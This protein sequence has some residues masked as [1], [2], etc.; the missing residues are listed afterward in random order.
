[1]KTAIVI[2]TYNEA[3]NIEKLI[4]EILK[5]APQADI[6]VVDDNSPD[7]TAKK[8][9]KLREDNKNIHCLLRKEN[10]GRGFAGVAGFQYALS[11]NA[12]FI[13]E[14]DAD[15]SHDPRYIPFFI[16]AIKSADVVIGSRFIKGGEDINRGIVRRIVSVLANAYL[17]VALGVRVKDCTSGYRCFRAQALKKIDLNTARSSGPSILEEILF[18]CRNLT[19]KEI[20]ICFVDR[21][22]GS[23][24][25]DSGKLLQC[26]FIPWVL[27]LKSKK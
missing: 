19:I 15:F 16:E 4:F 9:F 18:L 12:D 22:V 14:M 7:G 6:I 3:G 25:L 24:K 1:M 20:P 5:F 17:G 27:R 10:R 26:L 13:I 11:L 21:K 8:V 23:S 2:P